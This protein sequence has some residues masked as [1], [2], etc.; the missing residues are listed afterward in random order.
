MR[1]SSQPLQHITRVPRAAWGMQTGLLHLLRIH[2]VFFR[3]LSCITLTDALLLSELNLASLATE[4]AAFHAVRQG[5]EKQNAPL[6]GPKPAV[7]A[8]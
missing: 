5:L 8:E 3:S 6:N 2:V 7:H 4:A 1:M